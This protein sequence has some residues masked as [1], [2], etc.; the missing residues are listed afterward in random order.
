M[1]HERKIFEHYYVRGET[2]PPRLDPNV[3]VVVL[4]VFEEEFDA[5]TASP[6]SRGGTIGDGVFLLFL[7]SRDIRRGVSGVL[8]GGRGSGSTRRYLDTLS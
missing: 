5:E 7:S 1:I 6:R 2:R 4:D 8:G 3:M